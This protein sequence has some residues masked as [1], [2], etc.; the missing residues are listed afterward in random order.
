VAQ[1]VGFESEYS[2]CTMKQD[3]CSWL[4]SDEAHLHIDCNATDTT[5]NSDLVSYFVAIGTSAITSFIG[6]R[7]ISSIQPPVLIMLA[8]IEFQLFL[9]CDL[10]SLYFILLITCGKFKR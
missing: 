2:N 10:S 1:G 4:E 5:G 9:C 7:R 6:S 8:G 3:Y